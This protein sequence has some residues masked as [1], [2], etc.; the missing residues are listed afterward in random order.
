MGEKKYGLDTIRLN[1][2]KN[3][4]LK[5]NREDA[6]QYQG[7]N[8]F[9]LEQVFEKIRSIHANDS[10]IDFGCGKGRVLVVASYYGFNTLTGIDFSKELCIEARKTIGTVQQKFPEKIYN[11]IYAN[12]AEYEIGES[13]N[14]F[15]FF[16]PFNEK[17]M[18]AVVKNILLSIN[19]KPRKIY[20][21]YLNPVH[22]G[23]F[24]SAGFKEIYFFQ[25]LYY[26]QASILELSKLRG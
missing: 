22:K 10:I 23:I 16:N 5:G 1:N 25:K 21:I 24:M 17:V 13:A 8:Y 7:A 14:V 12:A 18:L 19:K 4:T 20:I 9:L 15:F 26:I 2:L 6:E 3:Q 11:I